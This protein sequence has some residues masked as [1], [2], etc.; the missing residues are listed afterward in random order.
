MRLLL[1]GKSALEARWLDREMKRRFVV[2]QGRQ[3]LRE[4][5]SVDS[6]A[7][8]GVLTENGLEEDVVV[9]GKKGLIVMP[10]RVSVDP[11]RA[12]VDVCIA[13]VGYLL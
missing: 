4:R 10:W 3:T 6:E 13:G 7:K 5:V 1:A 2:V 8:Q 11:I 9:V 12:L